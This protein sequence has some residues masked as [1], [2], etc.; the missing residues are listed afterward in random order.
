M[1]PRKFIAGLFLVILTISLSNSSFAKDLYAFDLRK[2]R[3]DLFKI[4]R[5]ILPKSLTGLDWFAKL[6]GVSGPLKI[7]SVGGADFLSGSS[8]QPHNC[9][10]SYVNFMISTDG[11]RAIAMFVDDT[12]INGAILFAGNP[13][14]SEKINLLDQQSFR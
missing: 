4:Y 13:T 11:K 10:M 8:C 6:E 5:A 12:K 14:N 3:P 7:G 2:Q 1:V 9:N